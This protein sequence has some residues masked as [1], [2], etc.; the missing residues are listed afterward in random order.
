MTQAQGLPKP[1]TPTQTA[2][3]PPAAGKTDATPE[4][5]YML[6]VDGEERE[7][8]RSEAQKLLGKSAYADKLMRQAKEEMQRLADERAKA[9]ADDAVWDDENKLEEHLTKKGKADL[10]DRLA[11]KRL[12]QKVSE[13]QM[14]PEQREKAAAEAR[15]AEAEAKLKA[16][17]AEAKQARQTEATKALQQR[18]H[19]ELANA[20]DKAGFPKDA[21]S[22]YALYEVV[23]EFSRLKLPWDAE[24]IVETARENIDG[25]F[26]RL[27]QSV[28]KGLKGKALVDRL[29]DAIVKEVLRYKAEEFRN[30]GAKK[31]AAPAQSQPRQQE[32]SQYISPSDVANRYR[33]A[34]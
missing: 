11:R 18:M 8:S 10:L 14:T 31:Q 32:P 17:E 25:S 7:Y 23:S 21:D 20:A 29:G 22:F 26:K 6:T 5:K 15:A 33:G 30:G 16:I 24:R 9:A 27:E 28:L 34:R 12:E 3:P 1:P 13:S 2:T 19:E 4:P